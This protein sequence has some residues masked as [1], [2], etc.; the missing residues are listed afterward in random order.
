VLVPFGSLLA[1]FVCEVLSFAFGVAGDGE[2]QRPEW[3]S[4][5]DRH[6]ESETSGYSSDSVGAGMRSKSLT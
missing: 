4:V 2:L 3:L 6:G 1:L 5:T